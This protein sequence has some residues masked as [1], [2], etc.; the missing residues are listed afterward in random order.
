[1]NLLS[2]SLDA[3]NITLRGSS[4]KGPRPAASWSAS[5][6]ARTRGNIRHRQLLRHQPSRCPRSG[7]SINREAGASSTAPARAGS[8]RRTP[9]STSTRPGAPGQPA[10]GTSTTVR[11][12]PSW[13][14]KGINHP[15]R[16]RRGGRRLHPPTGARGRPRLPMHTRGKGRAREV[17]AAQQPGPSPPS[18]SSPAVGKIKQKERVLHRCRSVLQ[19]GARTHQ[20]RQKITLAQRFKGGRPTVAITGDRPLLGQRPPPRW[21]TTSSP[22]RVRRSASTPTAASS[23]SSSRTAASRR[24]VAAL[25]AG[26][27]TSWR[28]SGWGTR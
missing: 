17:V 24:A 3:P 8:R 19:A 10:D 23:S 27:P 21:S 20:M 18:P 25:L 14:V 9:R 11:Q 12:Y 6:A 2:I 7:S 4:L 13:T 22:T 26:W 28:P 15:R 16:Q 5:W 1:M